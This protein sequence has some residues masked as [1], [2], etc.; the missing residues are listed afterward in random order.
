MLTVI[1]PVTNYTSLFGRSLHVVLAYI[2]SIVAYSRLPLPR[3]TYVGNLFPFTYLSNIHYLHQVQSLNISAVKVL[4]LSE[5]ITFGGSPCTHNI[6]ASNLFALFCAVSVFFAGIKYAN[7]VTRCSTPT[8]ILSYW[9]S[10]QLHEIIYRY[11]LRVWYV[12][13][14]N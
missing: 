11:N 13:V 14:F 2:T 7:L 5:I 10:F 3:Y 8:K 12:F 9:L 4:S 6:D 1:L